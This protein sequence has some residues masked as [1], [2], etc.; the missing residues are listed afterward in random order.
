MRKNILILVL[1]LFLPLFI[2]SNVSALKINLVLGTSNI[3]LTWDPP[4]RNLASVK[5]YRIFHRTQEG[6]YDYE[7]PTVDVDVNTLECDII[8]P[9]GDVAYYFVARS[10]NDYVESYDSNEILIIMPPETT[11]TTTPITTTTTI[12]TATKISAPTR[13]KVISR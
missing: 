13:L 4:K 10:Y 3:R 1:I 12:A 7:N 5:G 6:K 2:V 8:K 9:G 11:S